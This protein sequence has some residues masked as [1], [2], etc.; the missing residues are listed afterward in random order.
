MVRVVFIEGSPGEVTEVLNNSQLG[1]LAD[2]AATAPPAPSQPI[3]VP[4]GANGGQKKVF[5]S[6]EV[7]KR[8]FTRRPLSTQQT[9]VVKTLA[10]AFPNWVLATDL[11]KATRFSPAQLAGLLGAF[12]RRV[13]HTKGYVQGSWLFD[14]DW[15]YGNNC[16][17]Y[18][19]SEGALNAAKSAG[20]V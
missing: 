7:A 13:S 1:H 6:E 9:I 19:L 4:G 10:D 14:A 17:N 3:E 20:I 16:Y 2:P 5:V 12:G 18:R 15:D 8:A 11:H